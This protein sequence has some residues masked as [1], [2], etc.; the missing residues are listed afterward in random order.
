M[1]RLGHLVASVALVSLPAAT[2]AEVYSYRHTN[3]L[4]YID[5]RAGGYINRGGA[6]G[7]TTGPSA[8]VKNNLYCI[9]VASTHFSS[10][11]R[12]NN[13][14]CIYRVANIYVTQPN[15][16]TVFA[17]AFAP[18]TP[19]TV[20]YYNAARNWLSWQQSGYLISAVANPPPAQSYTPPPPPPR[21]VYSASSTAAAS[22]VLNNRIDDF[23]RAD[24]VGW[25]NSYVR[26]TVRNARIVAA[27]TNGFV[28]RADYRYGSGAND[29][30]EVTVRDN[31]LACLSYGTELS[32]CRQPYRAGG[33]SASTWIAAGV[34]TAVVALAAASRSGGGGSGS[35]GSYGGSG[36]A[37]S[38]PPDDWKPTPQNPAPDWRD[39]PPPP[40]TGGLYGDCPQSGAGYGC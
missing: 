33:T 23:L 31:Q 6:I 19:V 30:V 7:I 37:S 17:R 8:L 16:L 38:G 32:R 18:G 14:D 5:Y 24:S 12:F 20:Y 21:P 36:S 2:V 35:S 15:D 29:W 34:V 22:A 11:F 40:R 4:D 13:G 3:G 28:A 39:R 1:N 26:G 9:P 25:A 10:T 27:N